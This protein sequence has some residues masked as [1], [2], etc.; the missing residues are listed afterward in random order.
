MEG[1]KRDISYSDGYQLTYTMLQIQQQELET[2]KPSNYAADERMAKPQRYTY[3]I[4]KITTISIIAII[5][6]VLKLFPSFI[7]LS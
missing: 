6:V 1:C 7:Q 2:S 3:E 4:Q 5:W